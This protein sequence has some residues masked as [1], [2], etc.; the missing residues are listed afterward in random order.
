V[1]EVKQKPFDYF[2]MS[3]NKLNTQV[4]LITKHSESNE[5][6]RKGSVRIFMDPDFSNAIFDQEF[7]G[8]HELDI[9]WSSDSNLSILVCILIS[10]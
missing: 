5:I 2:L 7:E 4:V 8:A 9:K 6:K 1:K 3:P 10:Y